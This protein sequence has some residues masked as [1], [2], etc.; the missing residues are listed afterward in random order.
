MFGY[1]HHYCDRPLS[2]KAQR[3]RANMAKRELARREAADAKRKVFYDNP[4]NM[5]LMAD[6]VPLAA[7]NSFAQSMVDAVN[8]YGSLTENQLAAAVRMVERSKVQ[9]EQ[10]RAENLKLAEQSDHVGEVGERREFVLA[11]D[12]V[13]GFNGHFGYTYGHIMHDADG[14][15]FVY[16]GNKLADA[17]KAVRGKATIKRHDSRDGV[18]QTVLSRPKFEVIDYGMGGENDF[19]ADVQAAEAINH[20]Y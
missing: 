2:E 7:K 3:Y 11:V 5:Q 16:F 20:G 4:D 18:A 1:S 19:D 12:R 15:V 9:A 13:F 10:R 14:N 17:G 6:L 8:H